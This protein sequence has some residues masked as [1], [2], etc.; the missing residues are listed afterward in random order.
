MV[1]KLQ[2]QMT[3]QEELILAAQHDRDQAQAES[4]H[5]SIL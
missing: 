5:L 3:E 4:Q 1:Q 2:E